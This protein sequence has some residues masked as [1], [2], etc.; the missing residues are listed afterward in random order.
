MVV[1][2]LAQRMQT[3]TTKNDNI[4]LKRPPKHLKILSL[5]TSPKIKLKY[6]ICM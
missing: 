6:E 4:S 2:H 5:Y 1:G 3:S